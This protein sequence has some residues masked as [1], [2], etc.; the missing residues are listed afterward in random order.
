MKTLFL[1]LTSL[2]LVI[3]IWLSGLF[4]RTECFLISIA[5]LVS[6][7][8]AIKDAHQDYGRNEKG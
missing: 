6:I 4:S 8:F 2:T 3:I 7:G 1:C 5:A